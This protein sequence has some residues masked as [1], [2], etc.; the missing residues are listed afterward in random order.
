MIEARAINAELLFFS[1]VVQFGGARRRSCIR[2]KNL[3]DVRAR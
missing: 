2:E 3:I 1:R